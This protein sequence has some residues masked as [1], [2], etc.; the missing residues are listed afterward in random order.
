MY[1]FGFKLLSIF[2]SSTSGEGRVD[3]SICRNAMC[4]V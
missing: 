3:A 4:H 1:E 2:Q